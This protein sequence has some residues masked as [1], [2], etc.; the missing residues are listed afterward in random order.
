V[1]LGI[2][3]APIELS[4]EFFGIIPRYPP[5]PTTNFDEIVA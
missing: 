1:V 4:Y 2:D 5:V 3:N